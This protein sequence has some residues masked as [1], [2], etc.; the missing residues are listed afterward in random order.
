MPDRVYTINNDSRGGLALALPLNL[1]AL[2]IAYVCLNLERV[3][4]W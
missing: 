1:I 3:K 4:L 2:I